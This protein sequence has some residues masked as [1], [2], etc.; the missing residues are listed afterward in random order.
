MRTIKAKKLTP[1]AFRPYGSYVD[2]VNPPDCVFTS[3][4]EAGF[5]PDMVFADLGGSTAAALSNSRAGLL[6]KNII[7]FAEIH[8]HCG[9]GM[10]PIDGDIM[11]YLAPASPRE[12]PLDKMEAF[13]IPKGTALTIRKGV[14]H[15]M[16][17][18]VSEKFVNTLIILPERTYA[19]DCVFRVLS[20]D[21]QI[22][23]VL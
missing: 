21:E 22:E 20:E 3:N 1:E 10:L 18:A 5:Y 19:N 14:W 9:E 12:C 17:F 15:G 6:E 11:I 7:K 23:V 16:Q 4:L 13:Y 2:L 8:N